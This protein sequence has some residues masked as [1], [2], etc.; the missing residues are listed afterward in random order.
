MHKSPALQ[1]PSELLARMS[2]PVPFLVVAANSDSSSME[3]INW[4]TTA[5]ITG[6]VL[7]LL[8]GI[9]VVLQILK[10]KKISD[11]TYAKNPYEDKPPMMVNPE[12][13]AFPC[14]LALVGIAAVAA[15]Y[16]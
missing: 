5:L 13:L 9:P 12:K 1:P 3:N 2:P 10:G 7:M 11:E 8:G 6:I 14:I 16:M 15:S 4:E